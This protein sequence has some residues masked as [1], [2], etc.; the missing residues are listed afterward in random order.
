[1]LRLERELRHAELDSQGASFP[2]HDPT[3]AQYTLGRTAG[4]RYVCRTKTNCRSSPREEPSMHQRLYIRSPRCV[5][6]RQVEAGKFLSPWLLSF[7][8]QSLVTFAA[9]HRCYLDSVWG[10]KLHTRGTR[11]PVDAMRLL[12]S[13]IGCG[14]PG[15]IGRCVLNSSANHIVNG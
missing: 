15:V 5:S 2:I 14:F 13:M 11:C 12:M 3:E 6:S 1:M 8:C 4:S 9:Y 7:F 10:W